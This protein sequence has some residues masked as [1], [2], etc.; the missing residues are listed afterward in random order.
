MLLFRDNTM[1][2]N[3]CLVNS[4]LIPATTACLFLHLAFSIGDNTVSIYTCMVMSNLSICKISNMHFQK[5]ETDK[6]SY[7]S[8]MLHVNNKHYFTATNVHLWGK[9]R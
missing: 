9:N 6:N 4:V 1:I 8:G 3:I 2:S 5:T 7:Y